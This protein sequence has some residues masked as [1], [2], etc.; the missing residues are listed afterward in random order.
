MPIDLLNKLF[1]NRNIKTP[2]CFFDE[3]GILNN[4]IDRFF[5]LGMVKSLRPHKLNNFIKQI[6]DKNHFYD[7]IKW[8]KVNKRNINIMKIIID[9]F[10]STHN[11]GFHCIVLPKDEMDFKE[12]FNNDFLK[13]YKSFTVLLLKRYIK[14]NEIVSIIADDYPAPK[15]DEFE[16]KVR[17]YVN[18][19]NKAL[20]IHSIIRINSKG[21]NLIQ[22][23]D[24]LMGTVNYE[25]KLKNSLIKHPSKAKISLLDYLKDKLNI[26][27]LSTSVNSVK[28]NIMIF[29]PKTKKNLQAMDPTVNA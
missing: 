22:L 24:L 25:F 8:N 26:D 4:P 23:A 7:E 19:H 6:R 9:N 16:A 20:S 13:V 2:V 12:Y 17:N 14:K 1:Q 27:D 15:K 11:T 5:V 29:T 3:R 28:F 21:S 10:F 18:D